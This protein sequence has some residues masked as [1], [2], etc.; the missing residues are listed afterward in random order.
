[1]PSDMS[2]M[3]YTESH[4]DIETG[5]YASFMQ[6]SRFGRYVFPTK[7]LIDLFRQLAKK[8]EARSAQLLTYTLEDFWE[9]DTDYVSM[10]QAQL[11]SEPVDT[12]N[13]NE[14]ID[15]L[16][17][18]SVNEGAERDSLELPIRGEVV[19]IVISS[20]GETV[21]VGDYVVS[22]EHFGR[23]AWYV[24]NGGLFGW[25]EV[26]DFAKGAKRDLRYARHPI[27]KTLKQELSG[28]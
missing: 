23:F 1:M 27:Y 17:I 12:G 20:G 22:R 16:V 11:R 14:T 18:K 8:P 7:S 13:T 2:F 6:L 24:A 5:F 3:L 21:Q 26:P 28:H 4:G 15:S 25:K 9:R 19:G 10:L